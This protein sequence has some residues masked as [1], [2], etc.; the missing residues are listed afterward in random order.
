MS[1]V[2]ASGKLTTLRYKGVFDYQG[3]Y[4]LIRKW[5]EE[6]GYTFM[7][8]KYSHKIRMLGTELETGMNCYRDMDA[9][10]RF[11]IDTFLRVWD[12]HEME[13][14]KNG[15]KK[16]VIKGRMLVEISMKVEFDY[17]N[18]YETSKLTR[19]IRDNIVI[20]ILF[21]QELETPL[22]DKLWYNAN[23]LQQTIKQFLDMESHSDLYDDMW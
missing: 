1:K 6:R 5:Y 21:W 4:R 8:K 9:F 22:G 7:E 13:V 14:I 23:K 12:S 15:K 2:A 19:W 18:K 20:K 3:L 17:T 10:T 11:W 16:K